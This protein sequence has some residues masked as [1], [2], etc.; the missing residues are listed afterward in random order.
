MDIAVIDD[1]FVRLEFHRH[2]LEAADVNR[3]DKSAAT[4]QAALGSDVATEH[5]RQ[6]FADRQPQA[7][8]AE[9]ARGGCIRLAE[10]MKQLVHLLGAHS[11]AAVDY[12]DAQV[13]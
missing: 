10:G 5:L 8:P 7:C 3:D 12:F 11:D 13:R 2:S 6:A 4:S 9:A 1:C